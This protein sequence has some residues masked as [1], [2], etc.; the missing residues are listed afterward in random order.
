MDL[1]NRKEFKHLLCIHNISINTNFHGQVKHVIVFMDEDASTYVWVTTTGGLQFE[2]GVFY[3][4][5]ANYE[6]E[7]KR[8]SRVRRLPDVPIRHISEQPDA[9]DVLL[10]RASYK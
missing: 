10:G 9:R 5:I 1:I 2:E 3:N 4:V 7:T 8:L 6:E